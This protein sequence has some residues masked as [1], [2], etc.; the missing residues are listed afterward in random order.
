LIEDNVQAR[1]W[2]AN[3]LFAGYGVALLF[4]F[5]RV[6]HLQVARHD[7]MVRLSDQNRLRPLVQQPIRGRIYDRKGR[8][9][10]DN[11]PSWTV[12]LA[13]AASVQQD[14]VFKEIA[15]I[16]G[17][18]AEDIVERLHE[19]K[20]YQ[21]TPVPIKRDVPFEVVAQFMERGP[22]LP[23]VGIQMEPR[24]RY[25]YGVLASHTL[26]YLRE[27]D[28]V[29]L[30]QYQQRGES[31]FFG[32]L[33]GKD[34]VERAYEHDLQ[35]VKGIRY[36]EVDAQGRTVRESE[37]RETRP[38]VHGNHLITTLDIELQ[39]IAESAFS[40]TARG[41]VV[42]MDPRDGAL[43][44]M[45]SLPRFDPL[46]FS[47]VL[48]EATWDSL[49]SDERKPLI[50]RTLAGL[51]P[52]ASI[53]KIVTAA[54]GL[55][56]DV[57]TLSATLD[58][59]VPGGWTLGNRSYHCWKEGHGALDV[60]GALEQSCDVFF[61]QV[62]V[63]LGLRPMYRAATA[64]G[65]GR[66]TGI[67]LPGEV[68]GIFPDAGYYDRT[69]G[70]GEWIE[71]GQVINLAIGQGEIL[72]TPLQVALMT[73]VIANG[74]NR[75]TP[76]LVSHKV[77]QEGGTREALPHTAPVPIEGIDSE[78]LAVVREGM[79][80]VING[81]N[82][83]ARHVAIRVPGVEVAGKTGTGQNPHGEDHAWFTSFAPVDEPEIVV[84]VLVEN[85]GGGSA[86][87]AP[88]AAVVLRAYFRDHPSLASRRVASEVPR[89]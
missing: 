2:R 68:A 40:D 64:F 81:E 87:A 54:A 37:E 30:A 53:I 75:V 85:G 80:R 10:V 49:N 42:A 34:G 3:L 66:S 41:A 18:P 50:N 44:V 11:R 51:Y 84:T 70:S 24:R 58:P 23:Y 27:I 83:T 59:C 89:R 1:R 33:V 4:L 79:I 21:Y 15:S 46:D 26:G 13:P 48:D 52:P 32:D 28:E 60:E 22:D 38:P 57:I 25:P 6:A 31:Y 76:Y 62:G 19:R 72:A 65:I 12:T 16:I 77:P 69:I 86:V 5:L 78:V 14:S 63:L 39:G 35:G 20:G 88:I 36:V 45:A 17:M 56:E 74:G 73:A 7:I 61:Y 55:Q 29:E 47:G 71:S 8:I 43:L 67:N 9:I 82:G